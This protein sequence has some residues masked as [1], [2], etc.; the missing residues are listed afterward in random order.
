MASRA[1]TMHRSW[2]RQAT[3]GFLGATTPSVWSA[4][5]AAFEHRLRHLGWIDGD[6]IAINY[7]WAEGKP[8]RYASIAKDFV[9]DEVDIIVTSGTAP[10]LAAKKADKKTPI[11]FAAAGDPRNTG[12]AAKGKRP[13]RIIAGLS[14]GQTGLAV[15]RL[16]K[17]RKV[18]PGLKRLA[19]LG[20]PDSSNIPL[21]MKKLKTRARKLK[22][23]TVICNVRSASQIA[24][25][26]K[27]LRGKVDALFVCTDPFVTTHHVTINIAAASAGLPTMHAFRDYVE[28]GGLM[29]YGPDFRSMFGNAADLVDQ[30]LR[31]T[32]PANIAI[33]QQNKC[34]LII[35]QSTAKALGLTIPKGVRKGATVIG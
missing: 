34:E 30:I 17:L 15:K 10:V 31:G 8:K 1:F 35:N 5:V 25:A 22:I 23:K 2:A 32:E 12:L 7:Q 18:V 19:I 20:N 16:D 28:A 9:R 24:P 27:R 11:V 21:E 33:E 29:S 14:N 13:N 26:I 3:I 6:N 4:F